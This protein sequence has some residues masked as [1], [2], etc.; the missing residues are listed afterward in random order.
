MAKRVGKK[1]MG[2]GSW[3]E[4]CVCRRDRHSLI[5]VLAAKS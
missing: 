2:A 3:V 4:V 5:N 1:L